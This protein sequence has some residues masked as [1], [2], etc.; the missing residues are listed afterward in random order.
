MNRINVVNKSKSYLGKGITSIQSIYNSINPLPVGYKL[1]LSDNWC[2][3]FVSSVFWSLGYRDFPFECSVA[4]M[5]KKAQSMGIWNEN[6]GLIPNIGDCIVYDWQD[7]GCGD[8]MGNP[9][10]IGIVTNISGY[11]L[12]VL[13]GNKNHKVG[14]RNI[15]V[16]GMYIRGYITPRY[17]D[18]ISSGVDIT[19]V[20]KD[21]IKGKYGV[22]PERK[23]KIEA[24]GI[25]YDLVRSE[26]NR[27]LKR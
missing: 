8:N 22:M 15:R 2:A 13:E 16:N 21:V 12:L 9:D 17:T 19:A 24:M 23:R 14:I 27:L 1:K 4:R 26:V 7:S 10:H 3:A 20:A 18:D 11:D 6:D 5:I 25:S